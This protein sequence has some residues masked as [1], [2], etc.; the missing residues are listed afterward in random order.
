MKVIRH[1][2]ADYLAP[3][4]GSGSETYAL[5]GVGFSAMDE[6]PSAKVDKSAFINDT[7]TSGT[8]T[9]YEN[10]FAFDTQLISDEVAIKQIYDIARNQK[11]GSDAEAF[12]VR[13]ELF[14]GEEGASAYPARRFKV[15]V[16]VSNINGAGTEIMKV[17]GTLHQVGNFEDGT[18]DIKTK[19]FTPKTAA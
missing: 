14:D 8:I 7:S 16:E 13:V 17:T 11:V 4:A 1:H 15:A 3:V 5:M 19:T 9:G 2:I 10:K 18:F 6:Q 12:Y